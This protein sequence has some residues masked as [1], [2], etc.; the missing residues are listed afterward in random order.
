M[1]SLRRTSQKL[2][3]LMAERSVVAILRR[4][5]RP[6]IQDNCREII[7]LV[8]VSRAATANPSI[9]HEIWMN[10]LDQVVRLMINLGWIADGIFISISKRMSKCY[11]AL[12][13]LICRSYADWLPRSC[14]LTLFMA[15]GTPAKPHKWIDD[16]RTH[17]KENFV[18]NAT[19][20]LSPVQIYVNHLITSSAKACR[21]ITDECEILEHSCSIDQCS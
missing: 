12:L 19:R 14:C 6:N 11:C 7:I 16:N 10:G 4:F 21:M 3:E 15:T 2:L 13:E 1:G 20:R 9:M 8:L 5:R 17:P 18:A